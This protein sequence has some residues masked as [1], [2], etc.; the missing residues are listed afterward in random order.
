MA[1]KKTTKK[2][3][4]DTVPLIVVTA[5]LGVRKALDRG[6]DDYGA[7]A[8]DAEGREQEALRLALNRAAMKH[9]AAAEIAPTRS[10]RGR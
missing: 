1:S 8:W 9:L 5:A 10:K 4:T 2:T 6:R 3:Q 7:E